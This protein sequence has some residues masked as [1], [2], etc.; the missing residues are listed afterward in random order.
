MFGKEKKEKRFVVK[1]EQSLL[2]GAAVYIV[3]DIQTGVNYL[4]TVGNGLNG[5]TP[6]LDSNGSVVI[7]R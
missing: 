3:V 1:E 6:L 4:M 2:I 5:I 7:D